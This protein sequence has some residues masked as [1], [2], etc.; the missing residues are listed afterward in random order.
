MLQSLGPQLQE[1]PQLRTCSFPN[2]VKPL[3][4]IRFHRHNVINGGKVPKSGNAVMPVTK[5]RATEQYVIIIVY[6]NDGTSLISKVVFS[7]EK[8]I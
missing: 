6:F 1:V 2:F 5:L 3:F 8:Q 7:E 4:E